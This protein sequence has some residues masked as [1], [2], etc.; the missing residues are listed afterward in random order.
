MATDLYSELGVS[1]NASDE[2][3]RKAYRSLAKEH[4]PDLHPGDKQAEDKFKRISAAFAILGDPEKRRRYDAG[5]IDETGQERAA[6]QY[7]REYADG[8]EGFRYHSRG[9]FED[10]GDIF[11]D[12]FGRAGRGRAGE[13]HMAG[14]DYRYHLE[15]DFLEAALGTKK[16][17]TLPEGGTL[18][19]NVPAGV[20]DGQVL[21]LRGKGEPGVGRGQPGDAL[22]ELSIRSHPIFQRDGDDIIVEVPLS[23]DEAVLGAKVQVPTIHG[24]VALNIPKGTSGGQTFRLRGKGIENARTKHKGD[25]HVRTRLVLPSQPDPELEKAMQQWRDAKGGTSGFDP[26]AKLRAYL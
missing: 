12:I 21:R 25:Q 3:I 15:I 10:F 11:G 5:E 9:G 23:I 24:T 16:R 13:F 1:R 8:T 17:V 22:I 19:I 7:Y 2:E 20:T 18:D 26:R 6:H 4:H 14:M